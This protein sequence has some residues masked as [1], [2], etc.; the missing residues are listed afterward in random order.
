MV[1]MTM[2]DMQDIFSSDRRLRLECRKA[3]SLS[4][5]KMKEALAM[6]NDIRLLKLVH[7]SNIVRVADWRRKGK[8]LVIDVDVLK[9]GETG[10]E[11]DPKTPSSSAADARTLSRDTRVEKKR[12]HI[13]TKRRCGHKSK[14]RADGAKVNEKSASDHQ[15]KPD[16][17]TEDAHSIPSSPPAKRRRLSSSTKKK[18]IQVRWKEADST[19]EGMK[20]DDALGEKSGS[21]CEVV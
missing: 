20:S 18:I 8:K 21:S 11:V 7:I 12:V 17:T 13:G 2:G 6:P 15:P 14:K 19:S 10:R 1:K 4:V 9:G 3:F 16:S 5:Q